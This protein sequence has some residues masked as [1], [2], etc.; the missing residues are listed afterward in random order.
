MT[1]AGYV[2]G[3]AVIAA[4]AW[5]ALPIVGLVAIVRDKLDRLDALLPPE[6]GPWVS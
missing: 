1:K 5:L 2:V 3:L 4:A 6:S